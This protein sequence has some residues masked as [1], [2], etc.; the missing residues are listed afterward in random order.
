M[1][2]RFSPLVRPL[3]RGLLLA[4]L[5]VAGMAQGAVHNANPVSNNS[6]LSDLVR[7]PAAIQRLGAKIQAVADSSQMSVEEFKQMALNDESL[8]VNSNGDVV[9]VDPLYVGGDTGAAD[10]SGD[11]G[12]GTG[13]TESAGPQIPL[14][15][16][17][18]LHSR[19]GAN[20]TIYMDFTGHHSVNNSWNHDI[21]FPP[22]NTSGSSS[23]FTNGELRQIIDH[24][25]Y[26]AEDYAIFD[27][28]VTTEEPTIG[29]LTKS[30][31]SDVTWGVRD[32]HTQATGGFGNGIGGIAFLNSFNDSIDNPVFAFNKGSNNG[33]MTGSHETGH[34]FGLSHD[35]LG[36]QA[37]H[38]GASSG[39]YTWGPIMG[40]PFGAEIVQWSNGDYAN[41]T[42]TQNDI[43]II[44]SNSNGLN[45]LA[46]DHGNTAATATRIVGACGT[47]NQVQV[48]ATITTRSDK[49][50]FKFTS[51]GGKVTID[52]GPDA[53]NGVV[54]NMDT[55]MTLY[56]PN[57]VKLVGSNMNRNPNARI[58]TTIG[59]GDYTVEI[60]GTSQGTLFSDY[61]TR[62]HYVMD[63]TIPGP[64]SDFSDLGNSLAGSNGT[65]VL[66]GTGF[67]CVGESIDLVL[68]NAKP[69]SNSFFVFGFARLDAP[70]FGGVLVPNSA[71]GGAIMVL[72]T[73]ALGVVTQNYTF[74]AG[75]PSGSQLFM[76]QWIK[77]TGAAT[78]WAASNAVVL[79]VP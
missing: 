52:A 34:S 14:S 44:A 27:V 47:P 68:T 56:D 40:A 16:A 74:P 48:C 13:G 21:M 76:Q 28:D 7:G 20:K 45:I 6:A 22:Y 3:G 65:P 37:Y 31:F 43:N 49:D 25:R 11:T 54:G 50:V 12:N 58:V 41:S 62:G 66:T 36:N 24:W 77:D 30:G 79:T 8:F 59:A 10:D 73:S 38:P 1:H 70:L 9:F 5:P 51:I 75:I 57:G 71:V 19:P 78:G 69:L 60:D 15:Q 35:G 67:A 55:F 18:L 23:T 72:P 46:D 32:V 26:M 63:I 39:N 42:N 29:Q 61:G 17:F 2:F 33:G 53:S 64:T 4:L